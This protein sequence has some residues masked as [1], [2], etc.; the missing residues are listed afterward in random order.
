MIQDRFTQC[1]EERQPNRLVFI[2]PIVE[3]SIAVDVD[4]CCEKEF[5][6]G[7]KIDILGT[8]SKKAE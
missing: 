2:F 5:G 3:D 4:G 7:L 8:V 1:L 6:F